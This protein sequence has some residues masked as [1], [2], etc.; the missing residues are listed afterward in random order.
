MYLFV[1]LPPGRKDTFRY[2]VSKCIFL[3]LCTPVWKLHI[4]I[5]LD[6]LRYTCIQFA[7]S[8]QMKSDGHMKRHVFWN[9]C[10]CL[11]CGLVTD[12][13]AIQNCFVMD[14]KSSVSFFSCRLCFQNKCGSITMVRMNTA[15]YI[16]KAPD[17]TWFQQ[18]GGLW[19][20]YQPIFTQFKLLHKKRKTAKT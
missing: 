3:Y 8:T 9:K 17:F 10:G 18:S 5:H 15:A 6:I 16:Y 1:S 12:F 4:K 20:P 2:H 19:P 14:T 7:V 13:S 11:S